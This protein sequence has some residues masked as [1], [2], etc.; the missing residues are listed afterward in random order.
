ML[1]RPRSL[2]EFTLLSFDFCVSL[3]EFVDTEVRD[4]SSLVCFMAMLPQLHPL[5]LN[6]E[7]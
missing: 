2:H 1:Y 5:G 6:M 7:E 3:I 4:T